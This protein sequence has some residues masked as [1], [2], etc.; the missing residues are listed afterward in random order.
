MEDSE[1]IILA[2]LACGLAVSL[3]FL[4]IAGIRLRRSPEDPI[5][6]FTYGWLGVFALNSALVCCIGLAWLPADYAGMSG[7]AILSMIIAN[8][9]AQP[10]AVLF[11]W[12][13]VRK[14]ML[15]LCGNVAYAWS[16][17]PEEQ[18]AGLS[19]QKRSALARYC[20][21]QGVLGL[22]MGGA[23]GAGCA[24]PLVRAVLT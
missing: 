10:I 17:I 6:R 21:V 3:A 1:C 2:A 13:G 24:W 7:M 18:L 14:L 23:I 4:V 8:I 22:V 19:A 16:R 11:L 12:A 15:G 9:L 5:V 20:V